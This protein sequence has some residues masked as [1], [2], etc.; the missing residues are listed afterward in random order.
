LV[1][2]LI[3]PPDWRAQIVDLVEC[4]DRRVAVTR[5]RTRLKERLRRLQ[6]AYFKVES[7]ED[8]NL[9]SFVREATGQG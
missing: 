2:R 3:L 6:N 8:T 5:E 7:D 4:E 9:L 1:A